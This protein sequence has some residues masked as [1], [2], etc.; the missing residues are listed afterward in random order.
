MVTESFGELLTW[1]A[2]NLRTLG[3]GPSKKGM[4]V[5]RIIMAIAKAAMTGDCEAQEDTLRVLSFNAHS[6]ISSADN[7]EE[8]ATSPAEFSKFILSNRASFVCI[9]ELDACSAP[10]SKLPV[11]GNSPASQ[12][13]GICSALN[14]LKKIGAEKGKGRWLC[15]H[16]GVLELRALPRKVKGYA[17]AWPDLKVSASSSEAAASTPAAVRGNGML[18]NT[19]VVTAGSTFPRHRDAKGGALVYEAADSELRA[20]GDA[21]GKTGELSEGPQRRRGECSVATWLESHGLWVI[22]VNFFKIGMKFESEKEKEDEEEE[23][24]EEEEGSGSFE[25]GRGG[26]TPSPRPPA[27]RVGRLAQLEQLIEGFLAGLPS[28][29]NVLFCGSF[30]CGG[31]GDEG[32]EG[33]AGSSSMGAVEALLASKG[34]RRLAV[35]AE[36]GGRDGGA[37]ISVN[38]GDNEGYHSKEK[39]AV[40]VAAAAT[41]RYCKRYCGLNCAFVR[42]SAVVDATARVVFQDRPTRQGQR[43][44]D[45]L[46]VS[47]RL[48]RPSPPA[49]QAPSSGASSSLSA[50]PP[51]RWLQLLLA[52]SALRFVYLLLCGPYHPADHGPTS[53]EAAKKTGD[54]AVA[55]PWRA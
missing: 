33:S 26:S 17:R 8:T 46:L 36:D 32:G 43:Q 29:G 6:C 30:H 53:L 16:W 27:S 45:G 34:F 42:G 2:S 31:G 39:L 9:Q 47:L 11:S 4:A 28:S 50:Q 23:E 54:S 40:S 37:K 52:L 55:L 7:G 13:S 24:K 35:V 25:G 18:W 5:S 19:S 49:L 14:A 12:A 48:R 1:G 15:E 22:N 41:E 51:P 10:H 3:G 44:Q 20:W 38:R 21:E